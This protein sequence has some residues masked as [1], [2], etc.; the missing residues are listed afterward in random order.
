MRRL[1]ERL[2]F[3]PRPQHELLRRLLEDW[4]EKRGGSLFPRAQ[5]L[6]LTAIDPE[7][8]ASFV[9][10]SHEDGREYSLMTGGRALEP[11]LGALEPGSILSDSA[12]PRA[13]VRLRRLFET[14]KQAGEPV[15]AE[16]TLEDDGGEM[17][18]F[19]IL[20]APLSESGRMVEAVLGGVSSRPAMR[21]GSR[22]GVHNYLPSDHPLIF[23][24]GDSV[25]L[26]ERVVRQLGLSIAPHEQREFEDGEHKTRPLTVVQARDA[27]VVDSLVAGEGQSP[28]DKLCRLLFFIGALKQSGA[29][30]VTAIVPYLCY[31]RKERQTKLRDPVTSR[32]VAQLFEAVGTDRMVTIEVHNLAAFQN[33]FRCSTEHLDANELFVRH[34]ASW[35][36]DT[37]VAV[38]SPDLGGAKRAELFRERLEEALGRAVTKGFMD[39]QRSMGR[40]SGDLFAGD[41]EGRSVIVIDDLI[42]TG[43]TMARVATACR[44]RGAK[45][46]SVAATHGLFTGGAAALW[47]ESAIDQVVITD[48]VPLGPLAA[49]PE[50]LVVLGTAELLASAIARLHS[51]ARSHPC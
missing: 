47:N 29:A 49:G 10:R 1:F 2:D 24:L 42:S 25:A 32:Y 17:S 7:A 48:T 11:L 19:E 5:Q 51:A 9:Y 39:K 27:Y 31:S 20:V 44:T 33:A 6:R 23:A 34:Y 38:V 8:R 13:A 26:G 45:R 28:N 37:P 3:A 46:I 14:V 12:K 35:V 43:T 18:A 30:R 22:R 36:G 21:L 41:V 15:L 40:V 16:F 4:E 50:R